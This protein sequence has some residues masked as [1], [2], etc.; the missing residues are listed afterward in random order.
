[1]LVYIQWT[2][3]ATPQDWEVFDMTKTND[4]R[5]LPK[6]DEP[7]SGMAGTVDN[8]GQRHPH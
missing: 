1:M 5:S 3:G 8:L 7:F 6:R 2:R 4:W